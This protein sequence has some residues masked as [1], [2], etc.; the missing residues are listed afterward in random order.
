MITARRA[1][2]FHELVEDASTG[3]ARLTEYAD[4][5]EVVGALRTVPAPVPDPAFVAALR[6]RLVAEA[7]SALAA[8]AAEREDTDERLRLRPFSAADL[9]AFVAYRS[10]PEVARYQ[11]WD[12]SYSMADAERFFASQLDVELGVPGAWVQLPRSTAATARSAA[13]APRASHGIHRVFAE[14]DD[15]NVAVHRLLERL[16]SAARLA[17]SRP[18]G[19]RASGRPCASSRSFG[20]NGRPLPAAARRARPRPLERR[21]GCR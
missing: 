16:G 20:A 7:E 8:A 6:D 10:A 15:R 5:M 19:S 21:A 9:A 12:T 3:G 11:S 1:Q 4:L 13:I 17:W 18:T 14:A 2:Q